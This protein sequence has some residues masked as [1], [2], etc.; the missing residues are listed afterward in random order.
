MAGQHGKASMT[1]A[2]AI[3]EMLGYEQILL[4]KHL[5]ENAEP[6]EGSALCKKVDCSWDEMYSLADMKLIDLGVGRIDCDA[7]HPVI[8]PLGRVAVTAESAKRITT[9]D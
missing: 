8:T 5:E 1:I 6:I 2:D 3:V 7:L 4:L 9:A